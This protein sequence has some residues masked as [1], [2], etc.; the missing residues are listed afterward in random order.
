MRSAIF[1]E[2]HRLRNDAVE[3]ERRR[4]DPAQP[5]IDER[6]KDAER[7]AVAGDDREA[8]RLIEER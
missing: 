8:P 5:L 7:K 4:T 1:Y 2:L 3:E 6:V